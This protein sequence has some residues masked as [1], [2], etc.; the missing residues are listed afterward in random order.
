MTFEGPRGR[1]RCQIKCGQQTAQLWSGPVAIGIR[2]LNSV[3]L[4]GRTLV[5]L[6]GLRVKYFPSSLP[7][8]PWLAL[9]LSL[10]PHGPH[11]FKKALILFGHF[12]PIGPNPRSWKFV[13]RGRVTV[14]FVIQM[15]LCGKH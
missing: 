15:L 12:L 2:L 6:G 4:Q 13:E 10:S 14:V 1:G 3:Y 5:Y 9:S 7:K 11:C 8:L